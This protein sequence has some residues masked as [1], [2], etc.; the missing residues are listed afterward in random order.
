MNRIFANTFV[1][2]PYGKGKVV[3][4]FPLFYLKLLVSI[5][6]GKGKEQHLVLFFYYNT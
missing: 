4:I 1:S 2:I 5:P 3:H 6:Y